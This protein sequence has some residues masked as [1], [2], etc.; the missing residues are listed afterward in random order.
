MGDGWALGSTG[1]ITAVVLTNPLSDF[2]PK[3]LHITPPSPLRYPVYFTAPYLNIKQAV[4]TVLSETWHREQDATKHSNE[5]SSARASAR[6]TTASL[7]R[8]KPK[9]DKLKGPDFY[10]T[11]AGQVEALK[12]GEFK[13]RQHS[14]LD[15]ATNIARVLI[16]ISERDILLEANARLPHPHSA[17]RYPWMAEPGVV[18]WEEWMDDS[19]HPAMSS[20][21]QKRQAKE[22]RA[23]SER[24]MA[25]DA[26]GRI[27]AK[28][29]LRQRN[30]GKEEVDIENGGIS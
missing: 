26:D 24:T 28:E 30:A 9:S 22:E 19:R 3:Q 18:S 13:G 16:A 27:R 11:I 20:D 12:L 10:L 2:V 4:Q 17:R 14:G 15:D 23:L 7:H 1:D 21:G 29:P 8:R 5:A 6:I 25:E